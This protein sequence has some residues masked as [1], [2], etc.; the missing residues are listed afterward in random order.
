MSKETQ[1]PSAVSDWISEKIADAHPNVH[2]LIRTRWSPRAFSDRPVSDEDLKVILDA[3]RWAPSSFN[4]QPWRFVVA[5]KSDGPDYDRILSL[6][7]PGNQAWAKNAPVLM[8]TAA[9]RTFSHDG[10]PNFHGAHDAGAAWAFLALQATALGLEVHGMAGFD[11][12]RARQELGVPDDYEV[13]TAIALGYR[14]SP[15][16]LPDGLR[17]RE[18]AKR[19]RKALGEV[20]FEGEWGKGLFG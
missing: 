8:I 6:L 14:G 1:Q 4:E 16:D 20:V 13:L 19:Q 11:R 18:V 12:E 3:A 15:E 7:V 9:K 17:K 2:Q 10:S 5:R